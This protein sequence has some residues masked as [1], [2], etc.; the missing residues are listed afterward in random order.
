MA[1]LAFQCLCVA[2]A[3][4]AWERIESMVDVSLDVIIVASAQTI[5]FS[6]QSQK[7]QLHSQSSAAEAHN[8]F[9]DI[10]GRLVTFLERAVTTYATNSP[11][12]SS[13]TS[14]LQTTQRNLTYALDD[15]GLG[16][17]VRDFDTHRHLREQQSPGPGVCPPSK[18]TLGQYELD[19]QQSQYLALDV[20]C[21]ALRNLV[22]VLQEMG[23]RENAEI[24][25]V[26]SRLLTIL[27]QVRRL[28]QNASAT[29]S[30]LESQVLYSV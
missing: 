18:M 4:R 1:A 3:S 23:G 17:G 8:F 22:V 28:L 27:V 16:S 2:S 10:Y 14:T 5:Q 7:C 26:D 24:T 9:I 19:E 11:P 25:K 29:L 6:R 13:I 21:R 12:H 20:I 15:Q 30:V